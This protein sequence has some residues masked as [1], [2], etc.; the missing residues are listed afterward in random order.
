ME[1]EAARAAAWAAVEAV[2]LAA[3]ERV[4]L[5]PGLTELVAALRAS[6]LRI[7][8]AT[9]NTA[10]GVDALLRAAGLPA[11]TFAPVLTREG[12]EPD[13]PHPA[14][15]LAA[16]SAWGLRPDEILM[17]GDSHDDT[18]MGRA[19]GMATCLIAAEGS[20]RASPPL[21]EHVDF[22]ITELAQLEAMLADAVDPV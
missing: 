19:A 22:A 15:A 17:V 11:D 14:L 21:P 5:Q 13:K 16:C 4:A 9:R 8:I 12:P 7:A 2:E 1:S 3:F 18:K 6:G 10:R 20:E